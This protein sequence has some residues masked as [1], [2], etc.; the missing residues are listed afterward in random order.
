MQNEKLIEKLNAKLPIVRKLALNELKNR[1]LSDPLLIPDKSLHE[2]N[3]NVHTNFSFSP[4]TST[5]AAYMAYKSGVKVACV[6]DYGTE[7]A[8]EEFSNACKKLGISAFPG[9]EVTL[10]EEGRKEYL[11]AIYALNQ[12]ALSQFKGLLTSFREVCVK[13]GARVCEKINKKLRKYDL[14]LNFDKD[15]LNFIKEICFQSKWH[16]L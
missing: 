5:L 4:Y 9:F 10:S 2:I 8:T 1:E 7:Y 16:S 12:S 14:Q 13:R 3:L 6:C 15:V 11:C